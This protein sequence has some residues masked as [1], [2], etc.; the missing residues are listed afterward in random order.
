[1]LLCGQ[2]LVR[3]GLQIRSLV[4]SCFGF[5]RNG[6]TY[7]KPV[8][9]KTTTSPAATFPVELDGLARPLKESH[10]KLGSSDS[11]SV[12]TAFVNAGGPVRSRIS[13]SFSLVAFCKIPV[14][15]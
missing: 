12:F 6:S 7:E 15:T 2:R 3:P 13:T 10:L 1:M 4:S 11:Q 14:V 5:S 8:I 9:G